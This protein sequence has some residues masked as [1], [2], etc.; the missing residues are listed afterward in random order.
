MTNHQLQVFKIFDKNLNGSFNAQDF[1]DIYRDS[2]EFKNM[3][4]N[5]QKDFEARLKD[6][7]K[8][9]SKNGDGQIT[10]IEFYN[11]IQQSNNSLWSRIDG[12]S[13]PSCQQMHHFN[14]FIYY[15]PGSKARVCFRWPM[16]TYNKVRPFLLLIFHK[17]RI[18]FSGRSA[19]THRKGDANWILYNMLLL[20][21]FLVKL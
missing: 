12:P 1:I 9:I 4:D 3:N 5:A 2:S 18:I 15:M 14:I 21:A 11:I 16:C 6:Q 8:T 13:P 17:L 20:A 10:P 7:F 19:R